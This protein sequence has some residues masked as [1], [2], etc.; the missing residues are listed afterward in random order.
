VRFLRS[1]ALA[2]LLSCAPATAQQISGGG[3]SGITSLTGD[4]TGT[5]PG[6]TAT[7]CATSSTAHTNSAASAAS[8]PANIYTGAIFTGGSGTTNFPHLFIQPSGATAATTWSTAGTAF[9]I[10][11]AT[12]FAGK[13]ADFRLAGV[14]NF[15]VSSVGAVLVGVGGSYL[16]NDTVNGSTAGLTYD[17]GSGQV[18]LLGRNSATAVAGYVAGSLRLSPSTTLGWTSGG[19]TVSSPDLVLTRKAAANLQLGAAD[20]A[21]PV[22]QKLTVQSVVAGTSNT[23]G[24]DLTISGS[25]GTGTGA[26]GK[27]ILKTAPAGSTGS[28]QN[29]LVTSL[30]IDNGVPVRPSYTVAT[31]PASPIEGAMAI[32]TDNNVACVFLASLTG[33]GSTHCP[34]GYINGAW[35]IE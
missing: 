14:Q 26:G 11:A 30:T 24:T 23:A 5:G 18:L 6:A 4:C 3:S 33:G 35:I 19:I 27:I 17:A 12:G 9:G 22:A 28:A 21:A 25:Q 15:S 7:T 13:L 32:V 16:V 31:L 29:A 2:A 10:N 8:T 34:V 1:L 20:A